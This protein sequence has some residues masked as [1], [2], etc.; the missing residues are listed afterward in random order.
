MSGI[1]IITYGGGDLLRGVFNSISMLFYGQNGNLIQALCVI[2]AMIGGSWSISRCFFQSYTDA[3]LTKYFLPLLV[4]PTLLI[5][6][7]AKVH[8][9]DKIED[10][11]IVVD[12]V[13]FLFAEIAS[14]ASFWGYRITT[15]IENVMHTPEDV[16]YCKTGMVFGADSMLDFSRLKLNNST[17]AQNLH[18]FTQQCVIYDIALNRYT[19]DELRK[20]PNLLAFLKDSTSKERMIHYVD[21]EDRS[22]YYV[23]CV[24]VITKMK[25][26]FSKDAD[27]YAKHE[28]LKKLPTAYQALLNLKDKSA[29][30]ISNQLATAMS[31]SS[32]ELCNDMIVVNAFNDATARFA[33][34]RAKENQRNIYQT[35]GSLA[36]SSLVTMRI[37]FEALIYASI[38]FVVPLSLL[39]GGVKIIGSWLFLNVWIQLW[40]P[41]Y[42][43][44]NYITMFCTEKYVKSV[45]GGVSDGFSMF[46]SAGLQEMAFDTAALSGFLSL[47]VPV[48]SFYILQ[49]LQ[50]IVHLSG[51]LMTPAHSSAIAAASEESSG[52]YSF[53]NASM[54][55]ISYNNQTAFQQN[56]AP[57]LSSGFFTDNYG[58]HQ[59]KY[60]KDRLTVNQDPSNLD[61]SISTAEAYSSSLQNA[62]QNAQSVVDTTQQ[63]YSETLGIAERCMT[64]LVQHVASGDSYSSGYNTNE[65]IALQ[66]SANFVKSM[67]E[68]WGHEHGLSERDSLEYFTRLGLD[69]PLIVSAGCVTS[70]TCGVVSDEARRSAENIVNSE[71]FQKHYQQLINCSKSESTNFMTDE[72]KRLVENYAGSLENLKSSQE[73]YS[74]ARSELNQISE[75]LSYVKSH[76]S[77]VNT[78]LNTEFSNWLNERGEMGA[79]FD[80]SREGTLNALRD[81]FVQEKCQSEIEGLKNFK[82]PDLN[83]PENQKPSFSE[84]WKVMRKN[85]RDKASLMD[86][87]PGEAKHKAEAFTKQ[88]DL[89]LEGIEGVLIKQEQAIMTKHE[90]IKIEHQEDHKKLN[91]ERLASK[92]SKNVDHACT[93]IENGGMFD[94][95]DADFSWFDDYSNPSK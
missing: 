10:K 45:M 21:P 16:Q 5:V 55:Q 22:M 3:F 53:S 56:T 44:V 77:S 63:A 72:G 81:I 54:G 12:N 71:D 18:Q 70:S 95:Q 32:H 67:A 69:W 82:H 14:F 49:N 73:Q 60:G 43:V 92:I 34:E 42:A 89:C 29:D 75:N 30:K 59:I 8:I 39:P 4:I 91:I 40:P 20:T 23:R 27:Y 85:V 88:Y 37:V 66:E 24:D 33:S 64:D 86:L 61:T 90:D 11:P 31:K 28:I 80:K 36:G 47:S 79:L 41:L 15:A 58:T 74:S 6:P 7:Q 62:E 84:D 9:I 17:M 57:T 26:Y 13:P 19:I 87:S 46:T 93:R 38:I 51:S 35:A 48:L 25:P 65:S 78:N 2:A 50:S 52:N 83:V 94:I 68:N 76:T 1:E